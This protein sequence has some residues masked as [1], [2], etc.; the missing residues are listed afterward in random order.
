MRQ[1]VLNVFADMFHRVYCVL[2]SSLGKDNIKIQLPV[3]SMAECSWDCPPGFPIS[4]SWGDPIAL[5]RS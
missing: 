1:F 2:C 3:G 4:Q 5:D